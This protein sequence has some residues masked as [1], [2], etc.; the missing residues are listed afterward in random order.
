MYRITICFPKWMVWFIIL[1]YDFISEF[2]NFM[3]VEN[4]L[5]IYSYSY[6]SAFLLSKKKKKNGNY[7]YIIKVPQNIFWLIIQLTNGNLLQYSWVENPMDRRAW[8]AS[9]WGHK[10][11]DTTEQLKAIIQLSRTSNSMFHFLRNLHTVLHSGYTTLYPHQ[12]R[13]VYFSPYAF[14]Y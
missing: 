13:K 2:T 9:L 10:E 12:E 7:L 4:M 6:D 14:Q 3:F 8:Q 11:L 1:S 5:A